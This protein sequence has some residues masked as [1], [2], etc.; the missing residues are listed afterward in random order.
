MYVY[1]R[2]PIY[3]YT[4]MCECICICLYICKYVWLY[5]RMCY[6]E[7]MTRRRFYSHTVQ[8]RICLQA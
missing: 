4:C 8:R 1:I 6:Y 5:V 7:R 3:V 2:N